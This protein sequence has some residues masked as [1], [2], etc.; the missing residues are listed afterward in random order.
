MAQAAPPPIALAG[1]TAQP[2]VWTPFIPR[3]AA[4]DH[5]PLG[6]TVHD[7]EF[8]D[9]WMNC[10]Y[11]HVRQPDSEVVLAADVYKPWEHAVQVPPPA[12]KANLPLGHAV[13]L[14][15]P[16]TELNWPVGH[17]A[18]PAA[19]VGEV[20]TEPGAQGLHAL[21][22][23]ASAYV[24]AL[25]PAQRLPPTTAENVPA[26]QSAQ[27]PA[28]ASAL[29]WPCRQPAHAVAPALAPK[30][31]A[32]QFAHGVLESVPNCPAGHGEQLVAPLPPPSRS[33]VTLPGLH[34]SQVLWPAREA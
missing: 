30:R 32:V 22:P 18:Q 8:V 1:Q 11:A 16:G 25:Q 23:F 9:G 10:P 14:R 3:L 31:P 28:P 6:H 34:A 24:V 26:L 17:A 21:L 19:P 29:Y 33:S 7:V 15:A 13:H 27:A 20:V 2:E 4:P 5:L 12:T